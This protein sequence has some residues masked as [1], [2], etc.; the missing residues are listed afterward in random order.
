MDNLSENIF[1][2][3]LNTPFS[4]R[5]GDADVV[6]LELVECK[7]LGSTPGQEQFSIL[8][9][10]P[11]EPF[12]QQMTYEMK[13]ETLGEVSIFLVPVRKDAEF[14]YYEAVF[15]RFIEER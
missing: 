3:N 11:L 2:D 9:A 10:G 1:R 14:M 6:E 12:L 15:N 13:H 5:R 7:D 8:F 4:I